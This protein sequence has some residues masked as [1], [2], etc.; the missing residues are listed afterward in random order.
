MILLQTPLQLAVMHGTD[1]TII[2]H[3]LS[4]NASLEVTDAEGNNVIHLAVLYERTDILPI[5][6]NYLSV[7][8][9]SVL[10]QYNH[11]GKFSKFYLNI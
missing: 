7:I 11:E 3:L 10:N 6:L 4:K 5:L 2:E 9:S 8:Q 1:K